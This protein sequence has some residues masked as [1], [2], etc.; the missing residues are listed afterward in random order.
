MFANR[1]IAIVGTAGVGKS[2]ATVLI[3]EGVEGAL[4][5]LG[6]TQAPLFSK[7][8]IEGMLRDMVKLKFAEYGFENDEGLTQ[9]LKM[10]EGTK[11]SDIA[12]TFNSAYDGDQ[13]I[14]KALVS[15]SLCGTRPKRLWIMVGGNPETM[16]AVMSMLNDPKV[17]NATGLRSRIQCFCCTFLSTMEAYASPEEL[18]NLQEGEIPSSYDIRVEEARGRVPE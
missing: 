10:S 15:G 5:E 11:G 2:S 1:F 6:I 3:R 9:L 17:G 18:R 14:R 8:S 16:T 13:K 12:C 7:G 4:E